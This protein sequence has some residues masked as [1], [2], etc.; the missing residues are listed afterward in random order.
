MKKVLAI[1]GLII[2]ILIL[3]LFVIMFPAVNAMSK[4]GVVDID[5]GLK[6]FT[7]GGGNSAVY[8]TPDKGA[9]VIVDT[10]MGKWAKKLKAYTDSINPNAKVTVINTHAHGDHTGGNKLY[11]KADFITGGYE[12]SKP[13]ALQGMLIK[14][15]ETYTLKVPDD[16]IE[17]RNMGNA[18]S[19][20]DSIVYFKK[21]K[22]LMTGDLVF[23]GWHPVLMKLG[24]ADS[25]KWVKALDYL[26]KNYDVKTAVP[27]HGVVSGAKILMDQKAYFDDIKT[28]LNDPA[29]LKALKEKYKDYMHM[30]I[31]T[32]FDKTAAFIRNSK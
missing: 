14:V 15:G 26:I 27:G 23:N 3:A 13:G 31:F 11:P 25:D 7:G 1:T 19:F 10:K 18:H 8:V 28:A 20:A 17:I 32:G 9:I 21:R 30:P 16:E 24:G 5:S 29:K 12:S 6:I 4:T 2:L 22:L